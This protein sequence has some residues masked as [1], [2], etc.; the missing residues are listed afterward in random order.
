M[1]SADSVHF[2]SPAAYGGSPNNTP[3]PLLSP[4]DGASPAPGD[5]LSAAV[6]EALGDVVQRQRRYAAAGPTQPAGPRGRGALRELP[7]NVASRS[8]FAHNGGGKA[9]AAARRGAA[10]AAQHHHDD[11][12]AASPRPYHQL[13]AV[14]S[15]DDGSSGCCVPAAPAATAV[16]A[17]PAVAL[18]TT[19]LP[20]HPLLTIGKSGDKH[21]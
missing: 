11:A 20:A 4:A 3:A 1:D 2:P 17:A 5:A 14:V 7:R 6:A 16:S 12:C 15:P 19:P 18:P 10:P 21:R 13:L 8:P 9:P